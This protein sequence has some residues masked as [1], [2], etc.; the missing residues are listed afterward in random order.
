MFKDVVKKLFRLIK[1]IL[2]FMKYKAIYSNQVQMHLVNSIKGKLFI[3]LYDESKVQIGK[4]LMS[5]GPL[6]IKCGSHAILKIGD[7]CFFNRNCSITCN[8]EIIIG[9]NCFFANNMVIVDH[10]HLIECGKI[11]KDKFKKK[12]IEIGSNVW[13]GADVVI[14]KGVTIGNGSVIAAGAVVNE[15][16]PAHEIWGGIPAKK[17]K[18]IE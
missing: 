9:N 17:I 15:N 3:E 13:C 18:N 11:Q 10:D 6:Y 12:R 7:N 2:T 5:S 4:F 1:S 8:E 14:L 16:V